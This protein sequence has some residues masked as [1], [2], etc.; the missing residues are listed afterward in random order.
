MRVV[1]YIWKVV[2]AFGAEGEHTHSVM[3]WMDPL[4]VVGVAGIWLFFFITLLRREPLLPM[5]ERHV[6]ESLSGHEALQ[7]G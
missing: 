3:S 6:Q 7:H 4:M 2:P 5:Y 1:D